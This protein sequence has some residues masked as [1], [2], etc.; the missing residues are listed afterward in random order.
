MYLIHFTPLERPWPS[1]RAV[2]LLYPV[3]E[4]DSALNNVLRCR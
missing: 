1:G 4:D 3:A 2:S